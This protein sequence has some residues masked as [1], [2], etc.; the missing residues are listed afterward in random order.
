MKKIINLLNY[1]SN[2]YIHKFLYE[3]KKKQFC[4]I[5]VEHKA[6]PNTELV[7]YKFTVKP[8]E[9]CILSLTPVAVNEVVF[10][11]T[12]YT[13]NSSSGY[14]LRSLCILLSYHT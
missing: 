7:E 13:P 12:N 9:L 11:T 1:T 8:L 3:L 2:N 5:Y 14:I 4:V 10:P 6:T